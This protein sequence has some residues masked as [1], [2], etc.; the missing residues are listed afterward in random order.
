MIFHAKRGPHDTN[1]IRQINKK[2][3][4]EIWA[5]IKK[6]LKKNKQIK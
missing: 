3:T 1:V 4:N 2:S 6:S 5:N